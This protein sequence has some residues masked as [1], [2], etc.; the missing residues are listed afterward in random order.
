MEWAGLPEEYIMCCM[1]KERE[2]EA[3]VGVGVVGSGRKEARCCVWVHVHV[4][5]TLSVVVVEESRKSR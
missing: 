5:A 1:V 2:R 4:L 3:L